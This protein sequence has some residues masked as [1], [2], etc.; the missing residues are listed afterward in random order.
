MCTSLNLLNCVFRTI[1]VILLW[2]IVTIT[3]MILTHHLFSP[4]FLLQIQTLLDP[5]S[6][7]SISSPSQSLFPL[8]EFMKISCPLVNFLFTQVET[9]E[10][11]RR[12]K[13]QKRKKKNQKRKKKKKRILR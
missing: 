9:K 12:K 13:N 4:L 2:T 3:S 6:K 7:Y 11:G 10:S 1:G 5:P 8:N